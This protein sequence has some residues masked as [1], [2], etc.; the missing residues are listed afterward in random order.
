MARRA[1]LEAVLD[2]GPQHGQ[3]LEGAG[4]HHEAAPGLLGDDVGGVATLGHDAVDLVAAA[5]VL[6]DEADGHLGHH[7]GVRGVHALLGRRRGVRG[8]ARVVDLEVVDGQAGGDE[9]VLGP[10]VD[11]H[12]GVGAVEGAALEE[13]DLAAAALLGRRAEHGDGEAEVVGHAGQGHPRPERRG[14]D[15]VVPAGV[16]HRRAGR[17]TRRR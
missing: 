11:H 15:E 10:G 13:Q 2:A 7:H 16:A 9:A 1:R 8:P 3:V 17:R 5:Q 4:P 14:G 6:A 12:R